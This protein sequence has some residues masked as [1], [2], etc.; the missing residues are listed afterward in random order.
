MTTERQPLRRKD[1]R[2]GR[3][4]EAPVQ[5]MTI[6]LVPPSLR[7]ESGKAAPLSLIDPALT[8]QPGQTVRVDARGV[9]PPD[10]QFKAVARV[11]LKREAGDSA[12]EVEDAKDPNITY[13]WDTSMLDALVDIGAKFAQFGADMERPGFLEEIA[14]TEA[15]P[16]Y[17]YIQGVLERRI[18]NN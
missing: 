3:E 11:G 9:L 6:E 18:P 8:F 7:P 14:G 2:E 15:E 12:L 17:R 1:P 4:R 10:W 13:S 5:S 16:T